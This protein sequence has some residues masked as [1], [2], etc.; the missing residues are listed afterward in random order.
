M[1]T[2]LTDN[3]GDMNATKTVP[4]STVTDG[5]AKA[6]AFGSSVAI[7]QSYNA[8]SF[9]DN[10]V[11][12]FQTSFTNVLAAQGTGSGAHEG[13]GNRTIVL[14]T[15]TTITE[16]RVYDPAAATLSDAQWMYDIFGDLA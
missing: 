15:G 10:G 8:T 12:N 6:W 9:V 3:I 5:T 14:N 7:V 16:I 13:T 4:I 1:S 11:G 2:L